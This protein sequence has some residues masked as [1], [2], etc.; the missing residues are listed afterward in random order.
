MGR[1]TFARTRRADVAVLSRN[2]ELWPVFREVV[3][4][5]EVLE[6]ETIKTPLN[7]RDALRIVRHVLVGKASVGYASM[8][9]QLQRSG[10]KV[11]MAVDQTSQVVEEL[12]RLL[13]ELR[14]V[15]IAH[16]S[17]RDG[18]IHLM[19][20]TKR[21]NRILC[22]WGQSD[23][24]VYRRM[25]EDP[26]ET[27][28]IGSIRNAGYV[29]HTASA[30]PS[31]I[32]YPLLLVSQFS[33]SDEG[34]SSDHSKR[35][36]ILRSLK[37]HTGRYCAERGVPLRIALRPAVSSLVS[38]LQRSE[39]VRH[40]VRVFEG[41]Q[42]SFTNPDEPYSSYIASDESDVTIGVPSGSLTE[43]FAR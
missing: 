19:M 10:V 33:S 6:L 37:R 11:L 26:V 21:E 32:Q 40:Y 1:L 27:R 17:I 3:A 4:G 25:V 36:Q 2:L 23:I 9:A 7:V 31:A 35:G 42:L 29:R 16:G 12:G 38:P 22:V 13:P 24:D 43:S 8:A 34:D 28:A 39:E 18:T 5:M 14:Q 20:T 15:V 41:V 30:A